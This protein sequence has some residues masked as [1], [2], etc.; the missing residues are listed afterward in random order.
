MSFI[1]SCIQTNSQNDMQANLDNSAEL[2]RKAATDG[3]SLI[4]LPENVAFMAN[5][6][7]ELRDN[8]YSQDDHP[9][10]KFYTKLAAELNVTILIG[11]IA[12]KD[13]DK[14]KLINRSFVIN[15]N[16][17][18]TDTYDKIHLFNVELPNGETHRETERFEAGDTA[19]VADLDMCRLGMSI[20]YD[21]RFPMLYRTL[22]KGGAE[23]LSAPSAFTKHTGK[24]HWH[25]LLRARAIENGCFVVAP[26]QCGSHPSGRET[27][28]HSLIINPWGEILQ[29]A[30][31]DVGYIIAEI[32][33]AEVD[34]THTI[35]P[36]L[37][38]DK[39]F[40][41]DD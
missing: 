38:Y 36:S 7:S 8:S 9:A 6:Y 18:I 34:K 24:A 5:N 32:D 31:D 29:E 19:I 26:A 15:N 12:I 25:A 23:V 1:A 40:N 2:I 37:L 17:K 11:S 10:I 35:I 33:T 22:A 27:Y 21:L 39:G 28:G 13:A 20:C 3:A 41:L 4:A 16:G 30:G 14:E